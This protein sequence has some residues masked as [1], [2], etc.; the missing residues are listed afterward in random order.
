MRKGTKLAE[1]N[2]ADFSKDNPKG[3]TEGSED[4]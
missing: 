4:F 3:L 2:D 1:G